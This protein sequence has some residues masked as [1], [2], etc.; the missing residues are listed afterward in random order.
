[1]VEIVDLEL[2]YL[3]SQCCHGFNYYQKLYTEFM[4]NLPDCESKLY[5]VYTGA[6]FVGIARWSVPRIGQGHLEVKW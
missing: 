5:R 2:L 1:M 4:L 6:P 3:L